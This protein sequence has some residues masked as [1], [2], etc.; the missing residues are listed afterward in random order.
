[1]TEFHTM[2]DSLQAT[3]KKV[4]TDATEAAVNTVLNLAVKFEELYQQSEIFRLSTQIVALVLMLIWVVLKQAW[5]WLKAS[6]RWI[7]AKAKPVLRGQWE[8]FV[9]LQISKSDDADTPETLKTQVI[10]CL[11]VLKNWQQQVTA[12]ALHTTTTESHSTTEDLQP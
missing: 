8:A 1:M 11:Q 2:T 3:A 5:V 9:Q 10:Q 6:S 12:S 4:Q 7:W